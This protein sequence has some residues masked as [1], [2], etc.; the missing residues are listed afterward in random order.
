VL[1]LGGQGS[2]PDRASEARR[3][4]TFRQLARVAREV[5]EEL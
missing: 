4:S 2:W 1:V 3:V 5:D